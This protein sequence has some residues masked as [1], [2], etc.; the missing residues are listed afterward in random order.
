ESLQL[1]ADAVRALV[2]EVTDLVE[3][4]AGVRIE[5][6]DELVRCRILLRRR[7]TEAVPELIAEDRHRLRQVHRR[8]LRP[9]RDRR[10]AL[11]HRDLRPRQPPPL[12]PEDE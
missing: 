3:E 4:R 8:K 5:L 1:R 12:P 7:R 6:L 2:A 10:G 9:R 11:A